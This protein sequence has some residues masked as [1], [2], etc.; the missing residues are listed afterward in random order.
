MPTECANCGCSLDGGEYTAPWEDDD[1]ANGYIICPHC[2]YK[3]YDYS[4][5]D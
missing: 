2:K 3:N 1:N 4:D 5:D